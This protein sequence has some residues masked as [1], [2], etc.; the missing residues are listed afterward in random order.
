MEIGVIGFG[1]MGRG[2]AISA[3]RSFLENGDEPSLVLYDN[4]VA[5]E[6]IDD[7]FMEVLGNLIKKGQITILNFNK[8]YRPKLIHAESLQEFNGCDLVIEAI[9]E[10]AES[11]RRLFAELSGILSDHCV[12]GSNTSS[13]PITQLA[14]FYRL[15]QRVI[16]IHFMN[17]VPKMPLVEII[18]GVQTS[19]STVQ[20]AR[21]LVDYLGKTAVECK[22]SPGFLVNRMLVPMVNEAIFLLHEN[23]ASKEDI[24]LSMKLGT[25]H[26]MGPLELADFVGLDTLLYILNILYSEFKDDKYRPCPLLVQMVRAGYFGVKSGQGFYKY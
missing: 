7:Y 11:K 17:P 4:F 5:K 8:D 21:D 3:Y 2:I 12:L 19:E 1:L 10:D 18:K 14:S 25:N 6:R 9:K 26:P 23:A 20:L 22:D 24:D 16:G 13:I 15:P